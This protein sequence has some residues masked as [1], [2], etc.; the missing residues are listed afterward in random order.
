M[1]VSRSTRAVLSIF[2]KDVESTT[3]GLLERKAN[4]EA[5]KE[6]DRLMKIKKPWNKFSE[7]MQ[8]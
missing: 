2:K 3:A 1:I 7:L 6:K 5:L 4:K 8:R